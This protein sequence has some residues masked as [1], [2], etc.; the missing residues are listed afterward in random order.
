MREELSRGMALLTQD[1]DDIDPFVD[2]EDNEELESNE[3]VI[4]NDTD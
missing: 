2:C 3:T 1:K 4:Y